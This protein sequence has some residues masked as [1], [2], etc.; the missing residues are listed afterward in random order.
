MNVVPRDEVAEGPESGGDDVA[1]RVL[2]KLDQRPGDAR[3]NDRLDPCR[4]PIG[5]VRQRPARVHEHLQF[6]VVSRK[7]RSYGV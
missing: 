4:V 6:N 3:L 7:S 2:K 1:V 5:E